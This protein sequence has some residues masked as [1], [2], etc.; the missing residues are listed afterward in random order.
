VVSRPLRQAVGAHYGWKD[1]LAQRVSAVVMA[2]Y[3]VLL[4]AIALWNGGFD[5]A[6]WR[7]LFANSAFKLATFVFMLALYW[8]A[9][10]GVRDIWMDYIKP[11]GV[12]VT[13]EVLTFLALVAYVGWTI[14]ILWGGR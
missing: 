1:W 14:Q 5:Y 2:V 11:V 12:R 7:S 3:T 4:L 9:W 13:L 8:H 10:V 6:L